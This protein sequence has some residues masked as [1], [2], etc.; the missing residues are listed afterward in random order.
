DFVR[1][2]R[3]PEGLVGWCGQVKHIAFSGNAGVEFADRLPDGGG[4]DLIDHSAKN[5]HGW[6]INPDHLELID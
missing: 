2:V 1:V 3:G 4:H 5:K 6:Y